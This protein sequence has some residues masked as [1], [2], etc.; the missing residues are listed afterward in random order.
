MMNLIE[1]RRSANACEATGEWLILPTTRPVREQ[2]S[3]MSDFD[4]K[5]GYGS[6]VLET[7]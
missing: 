1:P 2:T 4:P 5:L 3:H 6:I 7:V